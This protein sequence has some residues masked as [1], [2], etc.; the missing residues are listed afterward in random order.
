MLYSLLTTQTTQKPVSNMYMTCKVTCLTWERRLEM[1]SDLQ[2]QGATWRSKC[3][4]ACISFC[5]ILL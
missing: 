2:H 5:S 1:N 4:C 3:S